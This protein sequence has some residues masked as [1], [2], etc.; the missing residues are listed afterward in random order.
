MKEI[1]YR[2]R[3]ASSPLQLVQVTVTVDD[4]VDDFTESAH[5][6]TNDPLT[7]EYSVFE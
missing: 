4:G 3:E 1:K 7:T 2:E 6:H 5:E